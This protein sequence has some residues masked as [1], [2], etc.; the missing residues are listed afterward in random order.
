MR[1]AKLPRN[2]AW[3]ATRKEKTIREHS[4]TRRTESQ[5]L[6]HPPG[7][8]TGDTHRAALRIRPL[9]WATTE[10]DIHRRPLRGTSTGALKWDIHRGHPPCRPACP[11]T[12]VGVPSQGPQS[13]TPG[14]RNDPRGCGRTPEDRKAVGSLSTSS[15]WA[16]TCNRPRVDGAQYRRRGHRGP[17]AQ[18]RCAPITAYASPARPSRAS[19]ENTTM[20][21][22]NRPRRG[23][24]QPRH[25]FRSRLRAP[26]KQAAGI[27]KRLRGTRI[28]SVGTAR[29]YQERLLQIAAR[30]DV[31][32]TA[33]TPDR[34][35]A[36][37]RRRRG[38]AEDPRHGAP[39][40]PGDDGQR[41]HAA[42]AGRHAAGDQVGLATPA[43]TARLLPGTGPRRVAGY[44]GG[45]SRVR[46]YVREGTSTGDTHRAA[47]RSDPSQSP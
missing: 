26:R 9:R 24:D 35:V 1:T 17:L 11:T 14:Q 5:N 43:E 2:H 44:P 6:G 18:A 47:L 37:L 33:L 42:A 21:R 22:R 15:P 38:G 36:Y 45:Y 31:A 16:M 25:R 7:T 39:G 30:I 41:H 28:K 29:N 13:G 27:V 34:A 19:F 40:H 23:S 32:L 12:E 4:D 8:S 10:G 3:T 46:D 20:A